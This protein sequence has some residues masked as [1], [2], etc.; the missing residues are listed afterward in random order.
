MIQLPEDDNSTL[1]Y[2]N[3][4]ARI[5]K[6]N[7]G[8]NATT[9]KGNGSDVRIAVLSA[10]TN[11]TTPVNSSKPVNVTPIIAVDPVPTKPPNYQVNN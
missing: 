4:N 9:G 2:V 11:L 5:F 7:S 3:P 6:P 8:S 1:E 10:P